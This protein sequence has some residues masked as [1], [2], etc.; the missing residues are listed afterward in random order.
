M[1]A[2]HTAAAIAVAIA[3]T[4]LL[5]DDAVAVDVE[6]EADVALVTRQARGRWTSSTLHSDKKGTC[7]S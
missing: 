7:N 3:V 5:R 6:V 1:E 4:L 2:H